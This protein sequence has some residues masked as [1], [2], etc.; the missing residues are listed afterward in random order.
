[1]S[2]VLKCE[3]FFFLVV[4]FRQNVA[5]NLLASL[6]LYKM[7]GWME[8]LRKKYP[9]IS[10]FDKRWI[11]DVGFSKLLGT[12]LQ[13]EVEIHTHYR[14]WCCWRGNR[15]NPPCVGPLSRCVI[16]AAAG[17]G[18]LGKSA[19]ARRTW[20][21]ASS[22]WFLSCSSLI[23]SLSSSTSSRT[24]SIKWLLTRSWVWTE[25]KLQMGA[26]IGSPQ[27]ERL[28]PTPLTGLIMSLKVFSNFFMSPQ[29]LTSLF[30]PVKS[31]PHMFRQVLLVPKSK[32]PWSLVSNYQCFSVRYCSC[33][34]NSLD[35]P[36]SLLMSLQVS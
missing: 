3:C 22:C 21:S 18:G 24:A 25:G 35:V 16:G 33:Y 20:F 26:G 11:M 10:P 34:E 2:S 13:F 31:C 30:S 1:M 27:I 4:F 17:E 19:C 8:S 9:R 23:C 36:K 5:W 15:H 32:S 6:P 28:N 7:D 29:L 14:K 12:V